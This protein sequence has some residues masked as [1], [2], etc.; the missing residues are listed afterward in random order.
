MEITFREY[1]DEDRELL[2]NFVYKLEQ[3]VKDLDPIKRVKNLPGF[4]E[5]ALKELL[6]NVKKQQGKI[7]LAVEQE[8][9]I[10]C[11]VGVIWDQ[12]EKNRLEIGS[13]K[14]GEIFKLYLEK[15]YRRKGLGKKLLQKIEDYFKEK[16]CDSIW[17]SVFS[18]NVHAYNVYKEFGFIDREIGMLKE[19]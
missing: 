5:L 2:L 13:H 3:Y 18:P 15:E 12:S 9:V 10:G 19:I 6:E 7:L 17:L 4:A 14:I 16:G 1:T 8:K 11:V